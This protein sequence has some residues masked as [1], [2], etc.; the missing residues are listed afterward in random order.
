[1]PRSF[2]SLYAVVISGPSKGYP[3]GRERVAAVVDHERAQRIAAEYNDL[4]AG[5]GMV[6]T[7]RG[8]AWR[9]EGGVA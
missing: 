4:S 1:L 7:V 9:L 6:A 8:V 5:S 3:D 2:P